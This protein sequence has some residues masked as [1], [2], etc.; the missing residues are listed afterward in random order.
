MTHAP[1]YERHAE[2][3]RVIDGDTLHLSVDLGCDVSVNMTVRLVGIDT[4]ELPTVE[5]KAAL[6]AVRT[7]LAE[8]DNRLV[9]RT[10][11]DKREKFGRYLADL[12]PE[13]ADAPT[14]CAYLLETGHARPYPF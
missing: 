5:G 10:V 14:L 1:F 7:W 12:L 2:V 8:H 11:K 9:V 4:P 6:D 13:G 3:L